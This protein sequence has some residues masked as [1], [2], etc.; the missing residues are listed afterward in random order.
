[1][2]DDRFLVAAEDPGS[3][4]ARERQVRA[5][6]QD[7]T[8]HDGLRG[9]PA[10]GSGQVLWCTS[11]TAASPSLLTATATQCRSVGCQWAK[12]QSSPWPAAVGSMSWSPAVGSIERRIS[13]S[14]SREK[15]TASKGRD[16]PRPVAFAYASFRV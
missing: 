6:D 1:P 7:G 15:L 13:G 4:R 3:Q 2:D 9:R 5:R 16:M 12:Y 8:C 11:C 14:A 10:A